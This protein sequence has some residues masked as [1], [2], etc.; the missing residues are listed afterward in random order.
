LTPREIHIRIRDRT[1]YSKE[2]DSFHEDILSQDGKDLGKTFRSSTKG[3]F[4]AAGADSCNNGFMLFKK[5]ARKHTMEEKLVAAHLRMSM[6][7]MGTRVMGTYNLTHRSRR[8][9]TR[10]IDFD[11]M[12]WGRIAY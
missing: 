7:V 9:M 2:I 12:S 10:D 6:R 8:R 4:V 1:L 5:K 11:R 3:N